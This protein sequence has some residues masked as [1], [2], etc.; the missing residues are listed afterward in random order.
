MTILYERGKGFRPATLQDM[1]R[2]SWLDHA[3]RERRAAAIAAAKD[4]PLHRAVMR[5]KCETKPRLKDGRFA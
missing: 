3:V 5:R 1:A 2:L 4:D